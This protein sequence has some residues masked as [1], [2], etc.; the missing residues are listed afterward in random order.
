VNH[1]GPSCFTGRGRISFAEAS[2]LKALPPK[3]PP[4]AL[5]CRETPQDERGGLTLENQMKWERI[6]LQ[7]TA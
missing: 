3:L 1:C 4:N 6:Q 7:R 2:S 5:A